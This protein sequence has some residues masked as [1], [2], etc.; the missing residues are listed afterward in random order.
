MRAFGLE[1][2]RA[3]RGVADS[4]NEAHVLE[5]R[6]ESVEYVELMRHGF[7]LAGIG[8]GEVSHEPVEYDLR[9]AQKRTG[10]RGKLARRH[11]ESRHAGV[12]LEMNLH[13]L[14]AGK[15]N[16]VRKR[17]DL[18]RIVDDRCEIVTEEVT[19]RAAVVAAH[20]QDRQLDAGFSKLDR[21]LEE[22]DAD[23]GR[24]GALERP[25]DRLRSV[26]V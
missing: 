10:N 11:T 12:E 24:A 6:P 9:V 16:L 23:P 21:L 15:P 14:R 17:F 20:Y 26:S 5:R 7:D 3:V 25:G 4:R 13:R 18:R 1:K 22:C 8:A 2:R 19:P